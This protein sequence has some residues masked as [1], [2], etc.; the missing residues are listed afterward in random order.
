MMSLQRLLDK[1]RLRRLPP[2]TPGHR[3]KVSDALAE[4]S[5]V[6]TSFQDKRMFGRQNRV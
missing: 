1:G 4:D 2:V 5:H 6:L 3:F